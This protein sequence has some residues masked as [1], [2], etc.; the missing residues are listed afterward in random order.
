MFKNKRFGFYSMFFLVLGTVYM[1]FYSGLQNDHL[2]VLTPYLQ[3]TYGWDDLKIT[4]PVTVAAVAVI[5][6]Y[7]VVGTLF[8]K[9]GVKKILVPSFL[10]LALGCAGIAFAG[11]NYAIYSVSIFLVR[12]LVVPLQ[13]GAFM[14]AANWFIKYRG[15]VLGIITAGSP[16]MSVVGIGLMTSL[17][18]KFGLNMYL[19]VAGVLVVLAIATMFGIKDTPEELGLF[20]DG[21][22]APPAS[23]KEESGKPITLKEV[24]S[25]VRAWK[26][27]VSYGILQFVIVAM[28]AYMAV[29]YITLSTPQDIPNL[30]VSK[31]LLWLSIGALAGIPMS[32][33]LGWID[34]KVGS[35]KA[36]L[37]L[38]V[39]YLF[40]VIPLAIMPVGG[41]VPLMAVWAFGVACMTGGMPTMHPCVTSYVY[42]R[43]QYMAA[44]KWIMTIQA[45]PM[46]FALTY[47]GAFNKMGNLN[48]A[49]Y[50]MIGMLGVSFV[51]IL[52]MSNIPDAN[53]A[54]RDYAGN[55]EQTAKELA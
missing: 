27:I 2:N 9:F 50:I 36:S 53:A 3:Q 35:I 46:S 41:S 40:A 14:L 24:L 20:P 18:T 5:A 51:T 6:L 42:G 54:D 32:Y 16:L 31:A 37:V 4:N 11:Q 30:F 8:V 28:M 13:M 55:R 21:A 25:D 49:Y 52:S 26:L 33:V 38:N 44:N 12:A 47:M 22:S 39:L 7:L 10:I 19:M 29:R 17:V 45:I 1:F 23:E 43:K 34:D 15:R 48:M